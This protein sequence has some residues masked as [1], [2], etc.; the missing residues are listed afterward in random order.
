MRQQFPRQ[1]RIFRGITQ[2]IVRIVAELARDTWMQFQV[3]NARADT[4][5]VSAVG[6]PRLLGLSVRLE[7]YRTEE[8]CRR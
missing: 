5:T 6:E 4:F 7:R 1:Q 2:E 3:A 8:H